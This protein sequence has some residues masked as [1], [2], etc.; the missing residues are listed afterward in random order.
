MHEFQECLKKA[1][2]S[3]VTEV[4]VSPQCGEGSMQG[5][6]VEVWDDTHIDVESSSALYYNILAFWQ[7][8]QK[9]YYSTT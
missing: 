8:L 6:I 5:K 9:H 2:P 7:L 3:G 4:C 1:E